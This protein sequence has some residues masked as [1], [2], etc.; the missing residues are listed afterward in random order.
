MCNVSRNK[1]Q[2]TLS[3]DKHAHPPGVVYCAK[4]SIHTRFS[5]EFEVCILQTLKKLLICC[6]NV[7][8][9]EAIR[10]HMN[11]KYS[12]HIDSI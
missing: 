10:S 7:Y 2:Q 12:L 3:V 1:P 11:A 9:R 4:Y 6:T 8:Q 5:F